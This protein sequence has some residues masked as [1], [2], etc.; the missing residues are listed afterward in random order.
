MRVGGWC[1]M[2]STLPRPARLTATAVEVAKQHLLITSSISLNN[3]YVV[4]NDPWPSHLLPAGLP[5][6]PLCEF[7]QVALLRNYTNGLS[8]LVASLKSALAYKPERGAGSKPARSTWL[9]QQ[10]GA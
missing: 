4:K 9:N 5:H 3:R 2:L 10:V 7:L 6:C 8:A 1:G